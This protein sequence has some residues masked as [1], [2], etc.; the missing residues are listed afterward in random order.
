MPNQPFLTLPAAARYL[1]IGEKHLRSLIDRGVVAFHDVGGRRMFLQ[2]DLD[3][4]LELI[5]VEAQS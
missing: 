1:G 4:Y 5:R 3:A 2:A